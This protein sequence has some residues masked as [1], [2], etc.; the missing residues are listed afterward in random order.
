[1]NIVHSGNRFMVYGDEV[2]TYNTLP[3]DTYQLCCN[4]MTGFYLTQHS[5]LSVNEKVYGPYARKVNKVMSTFD[6][7]D[8]NMGIIL[9]GPKGAG[10]SMFARLLAEQGKAKNLPLILVDDCFDGL[11]KFIGSIHQECIVLFDEFEKTFKGTEDCNPQDSLLSLFDGIDNGKKLYVITCNRTEELSSYLLN[12]PG[13]FHYHFALTTPT[14][15]EIKEYMEDNLVGD[16]KQ[17]I[18]KVVALGSISTFTYDVLRAIAFDLNQGYDLTETFLDLNIEREQFV[19]FNMK[20][21][22]TNGVVATSEGGPIELDMFDEDDFVHE[23]CRIDENSIPK[24][25]K[26]YSSYFRRIC[27]DFYSKNV[28]V[29]G[30]RY[31]ISNNDVRFSFSDWECMV[32]ESAE[33]YKVAEE[34]IDSFELAEVILERTKLWQGGNNPAYKFLV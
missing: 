23:W 33:E 5:D 20:V 17:Y 25:L 29:C 4:P 31:K 13:R 7:M 14:E 21:V 32:D 22:F 8:R 10:K 2:K 12:R 3:A 19:N 27:I 28:S 34:F 15:E 6:A 9:S 26:K 1:M 16:A 18:E 11:E 24:Q 30:N